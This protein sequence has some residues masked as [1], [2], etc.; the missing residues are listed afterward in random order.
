MSFFLLFIKPIIPYFQHVGIIP[1]TWSRYLSMSIVRQEVVN[2]WVPE[3]LDI[4]CSPPTVSSFRTPLP[5]VLFTPVANWIKYLSASTIQRIAHFWIS[6]SSRDS[7]IIAIVIFQIVNAP[8]SEIICINIFIIETA[9]STLTCE[10]SSWRIHTILET[11]RVDV[12]P[13]SSHPWGKSNRVWDHMTVRSPISEHPTI[14][15]VYI[16]VP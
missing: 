4:H 2:N 1:S 14:V 5:S 15:D 9:S 6:N 12:I 10:V 16:C 11:L 8:F 7:L 3:A 13:K